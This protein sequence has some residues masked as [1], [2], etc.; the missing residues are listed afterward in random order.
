MCCTYVD[1]QPGVV[2]FNAV[3]L[4]SSTMYIAWSEPQDIKTLSELLVRYN[5]LVVSSSG[6]AG[7]VLDVLLL[8]DQRNYTV[9]DLSDGT[10]NITVTAYNSEGRGSEGDVSFVTLVTPGN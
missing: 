6:G 9:Y 5:I 3:A 8:Y 1:G 4:N 2:G 10:Y 7:M